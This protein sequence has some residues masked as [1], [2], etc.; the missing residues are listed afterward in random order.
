MDVQT[1]RSKYKYLKNTRESER[2]IV[3]G[4]SYRSKI[5]MYGYGYMYIC[6]C[7]SVGM[8]KAARKTVK[9]RL[10]RNKM[11]QQKQLTCLL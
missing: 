6:V 2:N 10:Q 1:N 8:Q 9:K 4:H 3:N 11:W 7:V 5:R